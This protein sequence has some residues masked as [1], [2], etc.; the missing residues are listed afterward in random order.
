MTYPVDPDNMTTRALIDELEHRRKAQIAGLCSYCGTPLGQPT[1]SG[2]P[3]CMEYS[4]HADGEPLLITSPL[5][6]GGEAESIDYLAGL[7]RCMND[8]RAALGKA[9]A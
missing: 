4:R 3:S 1:K 2:S 6:P 7:V 5:F 9:P 8:V